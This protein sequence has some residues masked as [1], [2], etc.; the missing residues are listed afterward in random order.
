VVRKSPPIP[1]LQPSILSFIDA[2]F[3]ST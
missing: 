3:I 1:P 2:M